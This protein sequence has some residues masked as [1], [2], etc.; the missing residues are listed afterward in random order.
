MYANKPLNSKTYS[1][2]LI[3]PLFAFSLAIW[4]L[5]AYFGTLYGDLTRI[6]QLDESDFGWHMSQPSIP[7][8]KLIS[9]SLSD[10][11]IVVVGDSFSNG[12]VWQSRLVS[13]GYKVST[14]RWGDFRPCGLGLNLGE[15]LRQSGF[16]GR[17]IIIENVE[18]G[19]QNRMGETCH[20]SSML[21]T[22]GY[23]ASPPPF[24]PPNSHAIHL[25]STDPL[26]GEWV[27][28]AL[29]N[30]IRMTYLFDSAK[31]DMAFGNGR[32]RIVRINGCEWFSNRLCTLGLFYGHDFDKNTFS[33][34]D[35]I[36]AVNAN[37]KK[38]GLDAIWL[39]I[40]DKAT[41]YLG[42]GRLNA[43]PYVNIWQQF[44]KYP[45]LVAPDLGS[46][47]IR[48]SR[49]VKDLYKPNDV[50]LSNAGYLFLGDFVTNLIGGN[51]YTSHAETLPGN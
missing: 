47:F 45:E 29:I 43:N 23:I 9:A 44:A 28:G 50:H 14:L 12:L 2:M 5:E 15:L 21:N 25:L 22:T 19:F 1:L 3:I 48:Q 41:V 7:Q 16:K 51:R 37:F 31:S 32:T 38:A 24:E 27:I 18:H 11:D 8:R 26:G 42:Y 36:L 20:L 34:M 40:P 33:A 46:N 13:A 49:L 4:G 30:K 17:Y 6:G 10:A 35:N 39:A